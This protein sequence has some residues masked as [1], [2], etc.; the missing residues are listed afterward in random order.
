MTHLLVA[1]DKL[2]KWIEAKPIKKLDDPITIKFIKSIIHRFGYRHSIITDNA[3]NFV[4]GEFARFC[5]IR[6]HPA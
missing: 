3:S 6:R 2:T 4:K 5:G 1:V